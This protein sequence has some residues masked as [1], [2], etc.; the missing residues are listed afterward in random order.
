MNDKKY[1]FFH[2]KRKKGATKVSNKM[3]ELKFLVC[4]FS[5]VLFF[6]L[7]IYITFS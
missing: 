7:F 3:L 2:M 4:F 1:F 5:F 6:H